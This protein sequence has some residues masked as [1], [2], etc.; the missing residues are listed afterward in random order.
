MIDMDVNDFAK[1]W[2]QDDNVIMS[3]IFGAD[4]PFP[5][6]EQR[7]SHLRNY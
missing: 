4:F 7:V 5:K 6:S 3:V 1:I 2:Q